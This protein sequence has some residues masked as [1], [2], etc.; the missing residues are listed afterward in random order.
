MKKSWVYMLKCR[1]GTYY[2][3]CTTDL[4][5]RMNKHYAGYFPGYTKMRRPVRLVFS[6]EFSDI[7][8]AIT[9]ERRIKK[10]SQAKK[11][12]LIKGDFEEIKK[13]SGTRG[14]INVTERMC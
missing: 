13:L 3:G 2:T 9:M 10:W 1:G 6:Q 7:N 4:E 5:A 12:A 14:K 8:D 11:E